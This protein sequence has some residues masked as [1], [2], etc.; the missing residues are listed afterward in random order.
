MN[1]PDIFALGGWQ[2]TDPLAELTPA[3]RCFVEGIKRLMPG[4]RFEMSY[5][6]KSRPVRQDKQEAAR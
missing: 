4:Y 5:F 6:N 3:E 1:A 2:D